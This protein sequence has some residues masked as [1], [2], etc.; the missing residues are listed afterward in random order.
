MST[1]VWYFFLVD[2]RKLLKSSELAEIVTSLLQY[3]NNKNERKH[4][5]YIYNMDHRQLSIPAGTRPV[6]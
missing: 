3:I 5:K 4:Y 1:F 6:T 2:V